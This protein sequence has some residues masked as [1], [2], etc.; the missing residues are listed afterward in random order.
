MSD[1]DQPH[2]ALPLHMTPEMCLAATDE[3]APYDV[4]EPEMRRLAELVLDVWDA[5]V[6]QWLGSD[7]PGEMESDR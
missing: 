7:V 2:A 4:T 1:L 5:A 6:R 3:I